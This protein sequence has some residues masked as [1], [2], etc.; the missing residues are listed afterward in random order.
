MDDYKPSTVMLF[1]R[2]FKIA[3]NATVDEEIITRIRFNNI[4]VDQDNK[5][6]TS[7]HLMN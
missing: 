6:D 3:I 7:L 2:L 4:S 5:L 1:H